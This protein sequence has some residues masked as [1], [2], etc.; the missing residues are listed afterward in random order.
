MADDV[1]YDDGD[2]SLVIMLSDLHTGQT[3]N[4]MFGQYN[5]SILRGRLAQLLKKVVQIGKRHKSVMVNVVLLGDQISGNIHNTIQVSNRENVIE[6]V[7]IA[8]ELIASFCTDLANRFGFVNVYGVAGNHSRLVTNKEL[9]IHD[10]RLDDLITWIVKQTTLHI[11]NIKVHDDV[12]TRIDSGISVFELYGKQYVVVHG[13]QDILNKTG[14]GNLSMMLGII[15]YAILNG[16]NHY[17]SNTD[18]NGVKVVQG[19]SMA[20]SG[21]DYT[22][23]K[24]LSGKP[25]QTVL[26]CDEGG[27]DCIYNV[28]LK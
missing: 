8:S 3:F 28:E 13:D 16:H 27:I 20:G 15:P 21:D 7:E 14:V 17:P 22:I 18:I 23:E 1:Q 9:A 24:R 11:D 10:E 26:V 19:G 25:N 6:Q 5:T 12:D 2:N 4:S